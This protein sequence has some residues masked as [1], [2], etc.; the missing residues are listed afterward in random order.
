MT[1]YSLVKYKIVPTNSTPNH[2]AQRIA[3]TPVNF[4]N[5]HTTTI[6]PPVGKGYMCFQN[7]DKTAQA[8]KC[9]KSIIKT[10][11]IDYVILIDTYEQ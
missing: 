9:I 5:S 8:A 6:L 3:A 10:K 7:D 11:V 2:H 1:I 4:I